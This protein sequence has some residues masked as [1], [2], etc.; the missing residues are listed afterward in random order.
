MSTEQDEQKGD[1][2]VDTQADS[3]DEATGGKNE[4]VQPRR[5]TPPKNFSP[6]DGP[7][8]ATCPCSSCDDMRLAWGFTRTP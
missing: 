3:T 4:A 1:T 6:P 8:A 2:H 5:V 7:H